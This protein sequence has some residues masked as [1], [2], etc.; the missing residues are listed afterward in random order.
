MQNAA[1][2]I[3]QEAWFLS[4]VSLSLMTCLLANHRPRQDTHHIGPQKQLRQGLSWPP[5]SQLLL[6]FTSGVFNIQAKQVS[7]WVDMVDG[8]RGFRLASATNTSMNRSMRLVWNLTDE[9]IVIGRCNRSWRSLKSRELMRMKKSFT[10]GLVG[11][12]CMFTNSTES[13]ESWTEIL[14]ESERTA[15]RAESDWC[16]IWTK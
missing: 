13:D 6:I 16:A 15:I 5:S 2:H 3:G 8:Y 10:P 12:T 1:R 4:H 9:R 7:P 11:L 14:W